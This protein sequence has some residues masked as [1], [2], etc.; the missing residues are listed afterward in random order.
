MPAINQ[1]IFIYYHFY[2]RHCGASRKDK[3]A[4]PRSPS[5]VWPRKDRPFM[6]SEGDSIV[7]N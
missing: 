6:E 2:T 1:H 5:G 7:I 3:S 4:K